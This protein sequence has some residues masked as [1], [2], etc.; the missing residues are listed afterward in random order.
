MATKG[1]G[2]RDAWRSHRK[3]IAIVEV[4]KKTYQ[5]MRMR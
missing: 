1:A 4:V 5:Y 2:G 3:M